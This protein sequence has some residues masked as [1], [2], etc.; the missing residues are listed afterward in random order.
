MTIFVTLTIIAL[1]N[2][3][4]GLMSVKGF[5]AKNPY[6]SNSNVFRKFKKMVSLQ[7]YLALIHI[8][9]LVGA[10]ISGLYGVFFT[11]EIHFVLFLLLQGS[12]H[13][14]GKLS[15]NTEEKARSMRVWDE[16]V[17]TEYQDVCS[18]WLEKA[19]PDFKS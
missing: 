5:L 6:I 11:G 7:M 15:K 12:I 4:L 2:G 10:L 14:F 13:L 3:A 16:K 9:L 1:A 18:T 8:P 17:E 19:F